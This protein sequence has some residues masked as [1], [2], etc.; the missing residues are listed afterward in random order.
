VLGE[1]RGRAGSSARPVVGPGPRRRPSLG[2]HPAGRLQ[3]VPAFARPTR[4][5]TG[6]GSAARGAR[7]DAGRGLDLGAGPSSQ[8]GRRRRGCG[9]DRRGTTSG[10]AGPSRSPGSS[11]RPARAPEHN[12][13]DG[14]AADWLDGAN[15]GW[16][17]A[18]VAQPVRLVAQI[19]TAPVAIQALARENISVSRSKVI[20][21]AIPF[22]R[23]NVPSLRPYCPG[24]QFRRFF[25]C[26][27]RF[28]VSLVVMIAQFK[29]ILPIF[30]YRRSK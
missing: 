29:K 2:G 26:D 19:T 7:G 8:R 1:Q 18:P 17:A 27:A 30:Q 14:A 9:G 20:H 15:R 13:L 21:R 5:R 10:P 12:R 24:C 23:M 4:S 6:S 25:A 16:Q 11:R 22:V 3:T 28:A